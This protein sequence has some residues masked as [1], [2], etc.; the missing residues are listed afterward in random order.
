VNAKNKDGRTALMF[1]SERGHKE[2]VK[3]LIEKGAGVNVKDKYGWT[4]L[5]YAS[6]NGHQEIVELLKSY[7]AK[8]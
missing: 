7:G 4:A 8:K 5:K 2:V 6:E 3:L 1:A